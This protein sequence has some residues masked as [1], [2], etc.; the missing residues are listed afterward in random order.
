MTLDT[1]IN[2]VCAALIVAAAA[3]MVWLDRRTERTTQTALKGICELLERQD[4]A[5]RPDPTE[6]KGDRL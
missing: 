3:V 4:D 6:R 5:P 1:L 2:V